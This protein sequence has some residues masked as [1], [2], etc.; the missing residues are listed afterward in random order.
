MKN[1]L[2]GEWLNKPEVSDRLSAVSRGMMYCHKER[3]A[4]SDRRQLLWGKLKIW[5]SH[6][7]PFRSR[8]VL[9]TKCLCSPRLHVEALTSAS[10][11]EVGPLGGIGDLRRRGPR[12]SSLVLC[13][14]KIQESENICTCAYL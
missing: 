3:G 9:W 13:S 11:M 12:A 4:V 5:P 1:H 2:G 6:V 7:H 8:L 14:V 10:N